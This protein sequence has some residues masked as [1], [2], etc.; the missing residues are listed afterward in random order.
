MY[1]LCK[2]YHLQCAMSNEN[3]RINSGEKLD[4]GIG[5]IYVPMPLSSC[6]AHNMKLINLINCWI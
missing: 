5:T 6:Y 3:D 2:L 1:F 4:K